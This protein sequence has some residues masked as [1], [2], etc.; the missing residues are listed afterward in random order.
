MHEHK[1]LLEAAKCAEP[2]GAG[3]YVF[4]VENGQPRELGKSEEEIVNR[5]RFAR[6]RLGGES[7][8]LM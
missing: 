2:T 3:W 5:F 8:W 6:V 7:T 4:A 1:T